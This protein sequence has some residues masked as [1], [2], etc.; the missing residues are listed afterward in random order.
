[1]KN[2]GERPGSPDPAKSEG[3]RSPQLAGVLTLVQDLTGLIHSESTADL[4]G[5]AFSTLTRAVPF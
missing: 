4:F 1:M 5:H 3:D 2:S